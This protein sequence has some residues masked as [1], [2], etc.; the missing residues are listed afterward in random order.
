MERFFYTKKRSVLCVAMILI[1][2]LLVC[3]LLVTLTQMVSMNQ[4]VAE[5]QTLLNENKDELERQKAI[6]DFKQTDEYVIEW[7]IQHGK[8]SSDDISWIRDNVTNKK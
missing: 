5:L 7:A 8:L 2:V 4:R 6:L 3:M 1:L